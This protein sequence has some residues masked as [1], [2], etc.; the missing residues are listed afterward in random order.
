MKTVKDKRG[1]N[2]KK[3]SAF[4]FI[5]LLIFSVFVMQIRTVSA[6]D[7][8]EP[9]D[10]S[11]TSTPI[12]TDGTL[13][14]HDFHI[15]G[16][17]DW[18][19]FSVVS[20][21][22][23]TIETLNL[24]VLCDT[25]ITLYQTDGFTVITSDNNSG[26]DKASRIVWNSTGY[27]AGYYYV[28][29][30]DVANGSG[31]DYTYDIRI[32]KGQPAL[33]KPSY[34]DYGL[35]TDGDTIYNYLIVNVTVNVTKPDWYLLNGSLYGD[36]GWIDSTSNYTSL[37]AGL[38]IVQLYFN[39]SRVY[40]NGINEAFDVFFYLYDVFRAFLDNDTF[41]TGF[42]NYF[43]FQPPDAFF[44]PPHSDFGMDTDGDTLYNYLIVNV[45][46][47]VTIAG[48]YELEGNLYGDSGWI[49]GNTNYTYLDGGL[50]FIHLYFNGTRIFTNGINEAF[51]VYF[52]LYDDF[53]SF[54]DNESYT[55]DFYN[56]SLFQPPDAFF[57]PPHSHFG[58]DTDGDTLYDYL[59]VNVTVYVTKAGGYKLEGNLYGDTGW[60]ASTS[61]YTSL[62]AG[63]QFIHLYFEG[64][65]IFNNTLNETFNV[66]FYLYDDFGTYLDYDS[67]VLDFVAPWIISA[68][69][70]DGAVGVG[71]TTET[72][73]I[74][75]SEPMNKSS[76]EG[77]FSMYPAKYIQ[78]YSWDG[79]ALII[80]FSSELEYGIIYTMTVGTD[81]KDISGNALE[82]PYTWSFTTEE[83]EEE[84]ISPM[85]FILPLVVIVIVVQLIPLI[86]RKKGKPA[87]SLEDEPGSEESIEEDKKEEPETPPPPPEEEPVPEDGIKE[88]TEGEPEPPPPPPEE[89]SVSK[90]GMEED[91]KEKPETPP[92]P[93]PEE[94]LGSEEDTK[95]EPEPPPP[96]PPEEELGSEGDKEEEPGTPPPPPEEEPGSEDG[97][98]EEPETSPPP[99]PDD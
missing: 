52:Y 47:N 5:A 72:I 50:Q 10:T 44:H 64:T 4:I 16:D 61:N 13:Q 26:V 27:P 3:I 12:P 97:M 66:Y 46:F 99:P 19:N 81:A 62:D 79:N 82:A 35:D 91:T 45:T 69:P 94:E 43:Q 39:G 89:E 31:L 21:T 23:Y 14:N 87:E 11:L 20:G 63:L 75:F 51:E 55:T 71:V 70:T 25:K 34:S 7:I 84:G 17:T 76:V 98:E 86:K 38:Q 80:T 92:P 49:A 53:E 30:E 57:Q 54:L 95:E 18:V 59:I 58:M 65:R 73:V 33:L 78:D 83:K 68:T 90:D 6:I 85:L 1:F 36:S 77:A 96:P 88:D 60:I 56:Y 37:D 22:L 28:K 74:E 67:H 24:G 48:G 15:V 41:T 32:F 42:Y 9:D 8:Y 29:I 40:N 93:P 2:I